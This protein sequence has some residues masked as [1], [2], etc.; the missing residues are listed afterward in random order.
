[1]F[2]RTLA[3]FQAPAARGL[4]LGKTQMVVPGQARIGGKGKEVEAGRVEARLAGGLQPREGLRVPVVG[5]EPAHT[6]GLAH[7]V[8]HRRAPKLSASTSATIASIAAR[9]VQVLPM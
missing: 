1:M 6:A 5:E 9:M 7:R 8:S 3:G 4:L 2:V